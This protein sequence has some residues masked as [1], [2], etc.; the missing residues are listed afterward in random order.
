MIRVIDV[1]TV[2]FFLLCGF[3]D[4]KWRKVYNKATFP[5]MGIGLL[6]NIVTHAYNYILICILLIFLYLLSNAHIMGTGDIKF[7]MAVL[8]LQ[9]VHRTWVMF[10]GGIMLMLA[11]CLATNFWPMV[12]TFKD[13]VYWIMYKTPLPRRSD[14]QYPLTTFFAVAFIFNLWF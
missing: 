14:K 3:T 10:F 5:A 9:G 7:L 8:C 4:L 11:Y 2:G 12:Y 1:L 13:L 6:A